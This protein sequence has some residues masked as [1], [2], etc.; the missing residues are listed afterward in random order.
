MGGER[1]RWYHTTLHITTPV[2]RGKACRGV[3]VL[4]A[5]FRQKGYTLMNSDSL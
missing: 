5:G 3:G 4:V 2:T 1:G